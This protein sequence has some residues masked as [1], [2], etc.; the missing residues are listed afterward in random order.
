MRSGNLM[1]NELTQELIESNYFDESQRLKKAE[2]AP[3]IAKTYLK[4]SI[5]EGKA[6]ATEGL[7]PRQVQFLESIIKQAISEYLEEFKTAK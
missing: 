3:E 2:I 4:V 1:N 7:Q 5:N 6:K